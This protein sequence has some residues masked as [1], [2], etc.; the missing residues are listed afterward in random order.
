MDGKVG[1]EKGG[2]KTQ[3]WTV[4]KRPFALGTTSL[5]TREAWPTEDARPAA[6]LSTAPSR[7]SLHL[8]P[9]SAA[10]ITQTWDPCTEDVQRQSRGGPTHEI[11]LLSKGYWPHRRS[12]RDRPTCWAPLSPGPDSPRR[13]TWPHTALAGCQWRWQI[14][15]K[16][17]L[18]DRDRS[19]LPQDASVSRNS[20]S[21][22]PHP[23][24]AF[25]WLVFLIWVSFLKEKEKQPN[26]TN[27]Q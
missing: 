11:P 9:V 1:K 3:E 7:P 23:T 4:N 22:N 13:V 8:L 25:V 16:P 6:L 10:S 5:L 20:I 12:G 14:H 19:C 2:R 27:G 18:S 21:R 17:M 26:K 24:E 15:T